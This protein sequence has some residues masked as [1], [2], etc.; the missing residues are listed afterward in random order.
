MDKYIIH[1]VGGS[2]FLAMMDDGSY[3]RLGNNVLGM[4]RYTYFE[5]YTL[6]PD[7]WVVTR[8]K[9]IHDYMD[10]LNYDIINGRITKSNIVNND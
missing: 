2:L 8:D 3:K 1:Y 6:P 10:K 9:L 4:L 5:D 7:G